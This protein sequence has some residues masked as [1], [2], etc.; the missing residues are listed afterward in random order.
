MTQLS[1]RAKTLLWAGSGAFV[2]IALGMIVVDA[3]TFVEFSPLWLLLFAAFLGVV[4]WRAHKNAAP[5]ARS[6]PVRAAVA[7]VAAPARA[8]SPLRIEFE[9]PDVPVGYPPVLGVD[10]GLHARVIVRSEGGPAAGAAVRLSG[11]LRDGAR[12]VA[13][14]GVTGSD[15]AVTFTLRSPGVGELMLEAEASVGEMRGSGTT[16]LSVV[17]YSEEIERLFTE[18]RAYAHSSLGPD[19]N[20]DTAR[21]LAEKLRLG[22]DAQT[23]RAL[24]ELARIYELV[25]YGERDADRR[26]YLALVSALLV[27][28]RAPERTGRAVP[29][30]G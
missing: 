21:E 10:D 2:G 4:Y 29:V 23:S 11:M 7:D 8:S 13:G 22:A 25:A 19:S 12:F 9:T 14:E 30:E 5:R 6:V 3:D 16:S 26:L 17:R 1:P 15:G 20:A 27:L 18:F 24:L 28:E